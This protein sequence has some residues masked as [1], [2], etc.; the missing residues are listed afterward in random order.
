M[1][2]IKTK[3]GKRLIKSR[4][5]KII[6]DG[7]PVDAHR[8]IMETHLGRKLKTWEEVHH[9]NEDTHDNR[10]ENL[11]VKTKPDHFRHHMPNF[12]PMFWSE[13]R[14]EHL[15]VVFSG[16]NGNSAKLTQD[17]AD[18]IRRLFAKG[19]TRKNLS[20]RFGI[21][22]TNVGRIIKGE[23]YKSNQLKKAA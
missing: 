5:H 18:E 1:T 13:G 10:I 9:K 12:K 21:H 17:Q 20:T 11:E 4:Y 14:R 19:E 15:R 23:S 3:D 2:P 22:L 16:E 7:K 8:H 6:V